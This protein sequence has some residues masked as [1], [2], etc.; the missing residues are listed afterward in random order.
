MKEK[1]KLPARAKPAKAQL[2]AERGTTVWAVNSLRSDALVALL[3]DLVALEDF[4]LEEDRC[5]LV[6]KALA[7]L[8]NAATGIPDGSWWRRQIYQELQDFEALYAG[9][10][11]VNGA[12]AVH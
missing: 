2:S 10:N 9:W 7:K 1:A 11:D 8:T 3:D 4:G 12:E 5:V 6:R